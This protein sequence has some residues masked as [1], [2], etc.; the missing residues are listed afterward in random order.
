MILTEEQFQTEID[1]AAAVLLL[2]EML[3]AGII[4][5]QD[6]AR[7]SRLHAEQYHPFFLQE[8]RQK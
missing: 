4:D 5:E 2:R 8:T 6:F 1:Y 3:E 7:I